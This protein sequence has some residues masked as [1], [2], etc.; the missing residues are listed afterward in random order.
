M[1][2]RRAAS[3]QHPAPSVEHPSPRCG[4]GV[5]AW[6]SPDRE[7]RPESPGS[8]SQ[9][10]HAK[11]SLHGGKTRHGR[12]PASG[13]FPCGSRC[14]GCLPNSVPAP[15]RSHRS[16]ETTHILAQLMWR[17][18]LCLRLVEVAHFSVGAARS[19]GPATMDGAEK[20]EVL[21]GLRRR[22]AEDPDSRHTRDAA[23][24][25]EDE[26]NDQDKPKGDRMACIA[27]P[28]RIH[29]DQTGYF[30]GSP[31]SQDRLETGT[32]GPWGPGRH[33]GGIGRS[34]NREFISETHPF[35]C[36]RPLWELSLRPW[37]RGL[38]GS[39][40]VAKSLP[41]PITLTRWL[42]TLEAIRDWPRSS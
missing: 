11:R 30:P 36:T 35:L 18:V 2:A 8:C 31:R 12:W 40:R 37:S 5:Q 22:S 20:H 39:G 33:M 23:E 14:R 3:I 42:G 26:L 19:S 15:H 17:W 10:R 28:L 38:P 34:N 1:P 13:N 4:W 41:N 24:K 9:A 21:R 16:P 6:A 32:L 27:S 7:T 25:S 29:A